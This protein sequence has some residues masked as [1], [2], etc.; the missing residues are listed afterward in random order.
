MIFQEFAMKMICKCHSVAV[1]VS[2]EKAFMRGSERSFWPGLSACHCQFSAHRAVPWTTPMCCPVILY[3]IDSL[4]NVKFGNVIFG[5]CSGGKALTL[6]VPRP[7]RE[8]KV[9][10]CCKT[11]DT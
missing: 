10:D 8:R 9:Y 4:W 11:V 1:W 3:T 7:C 5:T 6:D 2:R